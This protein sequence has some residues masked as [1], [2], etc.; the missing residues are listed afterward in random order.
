MDLEIL[1]PWHEN[2][3]FINMHIAGEESTFLQASLIKK[4]F[5]STV[6]HFTL[7]PFAERSLTHILR[8]P[9]TYS[10][11]NFSQLF[12]KGEFLG[13]RKMLGTAW[14]GKGGGGECG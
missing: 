5:A 12:S 13:A 11:L 10:S 3:I 6:S 7:V 4:T 1:L 14:G 8:A 9:M 2:L